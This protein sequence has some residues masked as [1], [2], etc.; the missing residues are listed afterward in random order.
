[1]GLKTTSG[2]LVAEPQSDGP[3]AKAGIK[4]GDVITSVNGTAVKDS[5]D[6]ARQISN[7]APGA[8]AK[9]DVMRN[10]EQK[11]VSVTLEKMPNQ[12]Q[13]SAADE[14]GAATAGTPHLGISVAPASGVA[15]AGDKGVVVTAVDPDGPA[16]EHGLQSG[17]VIL[18]VAGK[19]VGNAGD[20]RKALSD[21]KSAGKKDVLM[22]VKSADNTH[23]VA[24][25][26]G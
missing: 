19:S 18:D 13:A 4:A 24:M 23:F 12:Q 16:A 10:G 9:L 26:I 15:G 20:L 6:L 8:A 22:R 1:M 14:E 25:P 17:D 2:A 21:A 11:T 7:M 5:R 3:A